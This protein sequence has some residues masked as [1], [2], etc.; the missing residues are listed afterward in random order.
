MAITYVRS[1]DGNNADD[2]LSWANAKANLANGV[3]AAGSGGRTYVSHSHAE[4]QAGAVSITGGTAASPVEIICGN[5]GAEPPTAVATTAT[6]AGTGTSSGL[7]LSGFIYI[8]GVTFNVG[9]GS[10]F[11]HNILFSGGS[12]GEV[13]AVRCGFNQV[14]TG[15][16]VIGAL[17]GASID[18]IYVELIDC[19]IAFDDS[20]GRIQPA[21]RMVMRGGS[22]AATG[23]VPTTMLVP[24]NDGPFTAEFYG[25]D[26]S[27][28]GSGKNLVDVSVGV[29][30]TVLFQDCK[31]GSS[32]AVTTGTHVGPGGVRVRLVNCDSADTNYRYYMKCYEG[33]VFSETTIVKSGS[34]STDGTT[35][36]TWKM[37]SSDNVKFWRPLESDWMAVWVDSTGS[38]TVTVSVVTDNVTLTDAEAWVE[39]RYAGTSGF[40]LGLR[41]NDRAADI[42]ASAVNQT[43]ESPTWTTTGIATPVKQKLE[44]SVTTQEKGIV[45]CRVCLAKPSTTVYVDA[46]PVVT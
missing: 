34:L 18:D 31:L 25:V 1:T 30:G 29:W 37:V 42:L 20:G 16:G 21:G 46:A 26:L 38:K 15:G 13:R 28:F 10:S 4:T 23:T 24:I 11:N 5:D 33:E 12:P 22:V 8:Y 44:V 14:G 39:V 27:A 32:V 3:T 2:G 45:W 6:V 17:G 9:S 35:P 36:L 7:N 41:A 40:P 19:T 43:S